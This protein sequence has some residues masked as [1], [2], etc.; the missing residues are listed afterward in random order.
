MMGLIVVRAMVMDDS[1]L[2]R[3]HRI[4]MRKRTRAQLPQQQEA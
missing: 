4:G 1:V 3:N 2:C